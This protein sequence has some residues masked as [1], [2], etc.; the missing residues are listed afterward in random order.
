MIQDRRK[1]EPEDIKKSRIE[2][3]NLFVSVVTLAAMAAGWLWWGGRL[4]A[5]V[6]NLEHEYEVDKIAADKRQEIDTKQTSDIA[7]NNAQ[8]TQIIS[9]LSRLE[10]KVD[11]VRR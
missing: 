7:V 2:R 1:P 5:R 10:N 3:A 6:D 8:F 9:T 11:A 4:S